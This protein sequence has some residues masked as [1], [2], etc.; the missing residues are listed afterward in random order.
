[1]QTSHS[2]MIGFPLNMEFQFFRCQFILPLNSK[3]GRP[4]RQRPCTSFTHIDQPVSGKTDQ[5]TFRDTVARIC[6]FQSLHIQGLLMEVIIMK[7]LR[8]RIGILTIMNG[9]GL[10]V[11]QD[12]T[13]TG[14]I[15]FSWI[16]SAAIRTS[17]AVSAV[18]MTS[19]FPQF[20]FGS[21][22]PTDPPSVS[23]CTETGMPST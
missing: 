5:P 15:N 7:T 2:A 10:V 1:M 18:G 3:S 22:S 21:G 23:L 4:S 13:L 17:P 11:E 19:T 12:N 9:I 14:F 16:L 20:D 8:P 6:L